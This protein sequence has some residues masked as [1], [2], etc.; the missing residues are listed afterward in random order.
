MD[1]H[2]DRADDS[3]QATEDTLSERKHHAPD[4][5]QQTDTLLAEFGFES[6]E[7]KVF[8]PVV[9]PQNF[10]RARIEAQDLAGMTRA[11]VPATRRY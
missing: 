3:G 1:G 6:A 7:I 10:I 4:L 8:Q 5:G 11:R 2:D 9:I